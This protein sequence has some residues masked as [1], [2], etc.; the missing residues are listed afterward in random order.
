MGVYE[1][2]LLEFLELGASLDKGGVE[3]GGGLE[4]AGVD[5]VEHEEAGLGGRA[6]EKQIFVP[7]DGRETEATGFGFGRVGGVIDQGG[8]CGGEVRGDETKKYGSANQSGRDRIERGEKLLH[9]FQVG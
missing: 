4:G 8:G 1:A 3:V 7:N 2:A 6:F 5:E 9:G